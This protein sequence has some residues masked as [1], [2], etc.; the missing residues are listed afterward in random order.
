[1]IEQPKFE[2]IKRQSPFELRRYQAFTMVEASDRDLESYQ[3]FRLAFD[4]I[5]GENQKQQKIS[6]TAPVVNQMNDDGIQ[7]TAFVMPPKM[8]HEDVP[9]PSNQSLKKVL[10]PERICA[11]YRFSSNPK[12]TV[13]R[14]YEEELKQWID[15]QGYVIIGNLQLARY[16]PPFIPGFLKHNELWFEVKE[17]NK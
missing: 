5:Q 12:M 7:T 6:M 2:L 9:N 13:I 1:M 11:V 17:N 4:F 14:K 16:N 3:G 8:A 15:E 10:V